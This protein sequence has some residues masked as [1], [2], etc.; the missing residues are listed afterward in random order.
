ML[1]NKHTSFPFTGRFLSIPIRLGLVLAFVAVAMGVMPVQVARAATI[2]VGGG[3]TLV[4][5]ITAAN[6]DT[7][8]GSCS[9]G[10]G[11]DVIVLESGATYN[12]DTVNNPQ[13]GPTGLPPITST[14]TIQGNG[15]T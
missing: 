14:V 9:A 13:Y 5:A 12:L 11:D 4:D 15:A 10:S 3:C 6:I 1:Q 7:A 2:S 8:T